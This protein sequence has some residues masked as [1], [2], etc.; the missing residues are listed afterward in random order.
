M[1]LHDIAEAANDLTALIE[2]AAPHG[3]K[4]P[5]H[6]QHVEP[7]RKRIKA[8]MAHYFER[9]RVAVLKAIKPKIDRE[10][11]LYPPPVAVKESEAWEDEARVPSGAEAAND[12]A[13][14]LTRGQT[15]L[16]L[17]ITNGGN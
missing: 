10:L 4:H 11:R 1:N 16:P 8:V 3:L 5:R 12:L 17:V 2:R 14:L 6:A 15:K 7:A 9:Q 13:E